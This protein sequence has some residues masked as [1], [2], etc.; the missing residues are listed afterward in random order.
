MHAKGP[1]A[2]LF[3]SS[4]ACC[5]V[6]LPPAIPRAGCALHTF[7]H[8][9]CQGSRF[10]TLISPEPKGTQQKDI[11][12][13][14]RIQQD[15]WEDAAVA[16]GICDKKQQVAAGNLLGHK[17]PAKKRERCRNGSQTLDGTTTA[18]CKEMQRDASSSG[19]GGSR[20]RGRSGEYTSLWRSAQLHVHKSH[21]QKQNPTD[22]NPTLTRA[23]PQ[24]HAGSM[25]LGRVAQR[26]TVG[27]PGS[28]TRCAS[29][30]PIFICAQTT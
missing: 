11:F 29:T 20:R 2:A 24:A 14:L 9:N 3:T 30:Q 27:R 23:A 25:E 10:S 16:G 15:R 28:A 7:P 6:S 13:F 12:D 22:Q 17:H 1:A 19:R 4:P 18:W 5:S 21:N 26:S 8:G